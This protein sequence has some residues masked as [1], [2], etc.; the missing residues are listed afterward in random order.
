MSQGKAF[1]SKKKGKKPH[2]E[3]TAT[4]RKG[5]LEPGH[6]EP[7]TDNQGAAFE[8]FQRGQHLVQH[9]YAGTGKTFIALYLALRAVHAGEFRKLVIVRSAVPTRDIGFLPGGPGEKAE[10]YEPVYKAA[11]ADIYGRGDAYEV[12]KHQGLLEFITTSYIRGITI[13]NAVVVID[14]IQNL[15]FHELDSVITRTGEGTRLIF[16]GDITQSDFLKDAEKAGIH[17]FMK[18]IEQIPNFSFIDYGISDIVRSDL[19]RDYIIAREAVN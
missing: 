5:N 15:S 11:C 1:G 17:R 14:E 7:M 2:N 13:D 19:V 6:I 8:A 12:L 10:I 16:S 9:G 18:I 3:N 4:V